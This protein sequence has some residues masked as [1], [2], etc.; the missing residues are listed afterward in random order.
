VIDEMF[1][2]SSYIDLYKV[3]A[4]TLYNSRE[5]ICENKDMATIDNYILS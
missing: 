2:N 4:S 1:K 5:I 3:I